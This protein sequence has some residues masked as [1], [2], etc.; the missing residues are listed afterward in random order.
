MSVRE[1]VR[2]GADLGLPRSGLRRPCLH[3]GAREV[4]DALGARSLLG[5]GDQAASGVVEGALQRLGDRGAEVG[6]Q[7]GDLLRG[8]RGEPAEGRVAQRLEQVVLELPSGGL[9]DHRLALSQV[10]GEELG[11]DLERA[12]LA[13][14]REVMEAR[15]ELGD[16]PAGAR[17][18]REEVARVD[19]AVVGDRLAES[20]QQT[21]METSGE[22]TGEAVR[23]GLERGL[24]RALLGAGP[25]VDARRPLLERHVRVDRRA[26][27]HRG[28][29]RLAGGAAEIFL[30][31]AGGREE[32]FLGRAV[33]RGRARHRRL[34]ADHRQTDAGELLGTAILPQLGELLLVAVG[35][36]LLAEPVEHMPDGGACDPLRG[37]LEVAVAPHRERG[38]AEGGPDRVVG[39]SA[40]R[41]GLRIQTAAAD[42]RDEIADDVL[43]AGREQE[44]SDAAPH[45][46]IDAVRGAVPEDH[47]VHAGAATDRED[48]AEGPCGGPGDA[49]ALVDLGV[50]LPSGAAVGRGL[51]REDL[52]E[53]REGVARHPCPVLARQLAEDIGGVE[54]EAGEI[55]IDL[56]HRADDPAHVQGHRR[57]GAACHR[58]DD[59]RHGTGGR[60][61]HAAHPGDGC[62]GAA[63]LLAGALAV[64]RVDGAADARSDL[65]RLGEGEHAAD[66]P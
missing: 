37:V 13:Q 50:G 14:A 54:E 45:A 56:W 24:D 32:P 57:S 55:A 2:D 48:A 49:E 33:H 5:L 52:A 62:R 43:E 31:E 21:V 40:P 30:H 66:R 17:Q 61:R 63:G 20:R 27:A 1:A 18:L 11:R 38:I 47:V 39:L 7:R 25:R 41:D 60:I 44:A 19:D 8:G 42:V 59:D 53:H 4:R 15:D 12:L 3:V 46:A 35:A 28:A 23:G 22:V 16:D 29:H 34:R 10:G 9:S 26:A 64:H 36:A 65:R 58:R 6:E 51:R